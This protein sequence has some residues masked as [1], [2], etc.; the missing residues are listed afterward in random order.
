MN[1]MFSNLWN[2]LSLNVMYSYTYMNWNYP[3]VQ[4]GWQ[5]MLFASKYL[6]GEFSYIGIVSTSFAIQA[7]LWLQTSRI[8]RLKIIFCNLS[9]A[10]MHVLCN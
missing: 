4:K 3:I 8:T 10:I 9:Y 6:I 5:I 7:M 1:L 2:I